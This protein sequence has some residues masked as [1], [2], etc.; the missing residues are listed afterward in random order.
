MLMM[1]LDDVGKIDGNSD[2]GG[3]H[4]EVSSCYLLYLRC[5]PWFAPVIRLMSMVFLSKAFSRQLA[6]AGRA[7]SSTPR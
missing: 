7:A 6:K 4:D 3:E 5:S 2:D 1:M